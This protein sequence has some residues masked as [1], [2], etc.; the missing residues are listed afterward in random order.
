MT[1][2]DVIDHAVGGRNATVKMGYLNEG[3]LPQ[4]HEVQR[5]SDMKTRRPGKHLLALS[6]AM[7]TSG[8][9]CQE[10]FAQEGSGASSTPKAQQVALSSS[11]GN[12]EAQQ[13][14]TGSAGSNSSV[15]TLNST[16]QVSGGH[17][18]S[19]PD[20]K[21]P[22]GSLTLTIADAIRRGL[23]FNLGGGNRRRL[24]EAGARAAAGGIEPDTAGTSTG[25]YRDERQG[26][27]CRRSGLTASA[28]GGRLSRSNHRW[29]LPLLQC[30]GECEREPQPGR[31]FIISGKRRHPSRQRR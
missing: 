25:H 23:Q 14:T 20:P 16:I 15:N 13:S 4:K 7:V 9:A 8:L 3:A 24:G 21:A 26:R 18:G 31:L 5:R 28:F 17:Q 1:T 6:L 29:S 11:A 22:Q 19:I 27:P 12:V 2:Q 30:A 10:S